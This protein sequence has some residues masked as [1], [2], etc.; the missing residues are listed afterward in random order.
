M[1]WICAYVFLI[2]YYFCITSCSAITHRA[3]ELLYG[4][5][6]ISFNN[7]QFSH[8]VIFN[9]HIS[10]NCMS[11]QN[12]AFKLRRLDLYPTHIALMG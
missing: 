4:L 7:L 9:N 2:L 3:I 12:H 10:C 1:I 11:K 5:A 8:C 6:H